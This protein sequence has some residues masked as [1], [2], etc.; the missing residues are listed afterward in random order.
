M[1]KSQV[2]SQMQSNGA[3]RFKMN[4]AIKT[5]AMCA[6]ILSSVL[7]SSCSDKAS[8]V[9][10]PSALPHAFI[11]IDQ[12]GY[13]PEARKIAVLR[14][15]QIGADAALEYVPSAQV[16]VVNVATGE[17]VLRVKP[18][19]WNAGQLDDLS[20]DRVWHVDF[21]KVSNVGRYKIVDPDKDVSSVPFDIKPN[22]YRP[23]F[24]EAVRNF[25]YQRA[26]KEK[27]PPHI[28]QPWADGA[29]HMQDMSAR[30]FLD[31]ENPDTQRDL[32]GGWYDA[33]D[34]NQYT[35]WT[36]NYI[37]TLLLTYAERPQI[38]TDNFNIP[39]SGNRVPDLLDEVEWGA[40]W[41]RRMQNEDGSC[42]SVLGRAGASPP[43]AATEPSY[44]GDASTS[45]SLSCAAAF[46]LTSKIFAQRRSGK[47]RRKSADYKARAI[48]AWDWAEAHPNVVFRNND[49]AAGTSGLA[50][51]QQEVDEAQRMKM[52]LKAAIYLYA[53]TGEKKYHAI[54]RETYRSY[55]IFKTGFLSD[56]RGFEYDDLLFYARL[57]NADRGA[58]KQILTKLNPKNLSDDGAYLSPITE[59]TWGSNSSKARAGA[60]R[61]HP[62]TRSK[63]SYSR[64]VNYLHYLHGVNPLG[65]V[66]LSNMSEFGATTSVSTFY[67]SWFPDGDA[68]YDQVGVSTYGPLSGY[69]VGGPNPYYARSGCCPE[70]CGPEG[71]KMCKTAPVTPPFGEPHMKSYGEFN[72]GWPWASWQVTENSLGYQSAYIRLLSRYVEAEE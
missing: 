16:H 11:V 57:P 64:G 19:A 40:A 35:T 39:E 32:Y 55:D 29:S 25:Y 34:Y 62:A 47:L 24:V 8:D 66:Y 44:Y 33:G 46:A 48:A 72:E 43:S 63:H 36:S 13:D 37:V 2:K 59:Y 1:S 45:A 21:S 27:L 10:K 5:G 26:G 50:A 51:G 28:D 6:L 69:L 17:T 60:L 9:L 22:V 31:K 67:H 61:S 18:K 70:S 68:K 58:A 41:L 12:F 54:I 52:R 3:V 20:G 56:F 7:L 49:E 15:P 23:V 30:R 4:A 53:I 42:L 65:L 38:F 14:N 71:N